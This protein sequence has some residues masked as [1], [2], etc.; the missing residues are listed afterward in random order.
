MRLLFAAG[1]A[2]VLGACAAT[3]ETVP[4]GRYDSEAGFA[5]TLERDW[6]R[7]PAAI[8]PATHGEYLTQDGV[9]LNRLHLVTLKDGASLVRTARGETAPQYNASGSELEVVDFLTA[10]LDEVG[11]NALAADDIRPATIDG[12]DAIRFALAGK[13]ENGLDVR[14]DAALQREIRRQHRPRNLR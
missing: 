1:C 4:A 11:Y 8:N 7:W 3:P 12:A 9:L 14:G 13:W 10:S 5:V 2:A 6:S